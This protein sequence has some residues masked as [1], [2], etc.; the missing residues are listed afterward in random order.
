MAINPASAVVA[1]AIKYD[2]DAYASKKYGS[3]TA[4]ANAVAHALAS[5]L[6]ARDTGLIMGGV[7]GGCLKWL[8]K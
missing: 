1:V 4:A 2:V 7:L 5:A 6:L 3:G 8:H